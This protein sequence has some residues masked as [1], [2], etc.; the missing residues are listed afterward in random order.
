VHAKFQVT[1]VHPTLEKIYAIFFFEAAAVSKMLAGRLRG[2][3]TF[4]SRAVTLAVSILNFA[5]CADRDN[6]QGLGKTERESMKLTSFFQPRNGPTSWQFQLQPAS[7]SLPETSTPP[8]PLSSYRPPGRPRKE[9][10][11]SAE[12]SAASVPAPATSEN[13]KTGS[14]SAFVAPTS[15]AVSHPTRLHQLESAL[16]AMVHEYGV[17]VTSPTPRA[18]MMVGILP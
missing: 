4:A 12:V 15:A 5:E 2:F 7:A 9:V 11:V 8:K 17:Q 16:S 3:I 14:A 6:Q 1:W 10:R 13:R 18:M